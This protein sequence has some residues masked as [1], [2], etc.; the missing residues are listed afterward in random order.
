MDGGVSTLWNISVE[1]FD[2]PSLSALPTAGKGDVSSM[3]DC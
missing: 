2:R 3:K 1:Y